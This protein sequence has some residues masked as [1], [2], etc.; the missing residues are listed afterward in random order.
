MYQ[1]NGNSS[2][3]I[4]KGK[5]VT[6]DT[7]FH[8]VPEKAYAR[9]TVGAAK[10]E[11]DGSYTGGV[12]KKYAKETVG[13]RKK[14]PD[15][16]YVGGVDPRFAQE[17]VETKKTSGSGKKPDPAPE[18]RAEPAR[19][20][21]TEP[22]YAAQRELDPDPK[23]PQ[24]TAAARKKWSKKQITVAA[25]I[26]LAVFLFVDPLIS[27]LVYESSKDDAPKEAAGQTFVQTETVSA[28]AG[29]NA[30]LAK[31][32]PSVPENLKEHMLLQMRGIG[33]CDKL[34]GDVGIT[35]IFA[36]DSESS[37]TQ[38]Q[39]NSYM[40]E[41]N[42]AVHALV[43]EANSRGLDLQIVVDQDHCSIEGV[44]TSSMASAYVGPILSTTGRDVVTP[45]ES[46]EKNLGVD[47]APVVFVFNK[48][49]RAHAW[50]GN[51]EYLFMFSDPSGF[52]H[53][54]LHL[55]GA[56]D[57]YYNDE[58]AALAEVYFGENV[59]LTSGNY[60]V[61]DLTAYLIGWTDSLSQSALKF[62]S[63]TAM[64][65]ESDLKKSQEENTFSGEGTKV[66]DDG[67]VYTGYM[68]NGM[69]MGW[70]EMRWASGDVYVGHFNDGAI[71]G[72]GTLTW[73]NGDVYE[74]EFL[75]GAL[76]GE[77]T[78]T[79]ADGTV[80]SGTWRNGEFVG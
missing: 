26:L 36:D 60:T 33:P 2:Y 19:E 8:V 42:V 15:G 32:L 48:N 38:T 47:E 22:V 57:Y 59:M 14:E 80:R 66:Y 50:Q 54:L 73:S 11:T 70:G 16:S 23:P 69:P 68:T 45:N 53:E 27:M 58:M 12:D 34:R 6:E 21:R 5:R 49:G 24:K 44:A 52:R 65:D 37:W 56:A 25:I 62:L 4:V 20:N 29:E 67:T 30:D 3:R 35:V 18:K 41:I 61:D 7:T 9:E 55:F 64:I 74:G 28:A 46:L 51:R 40:N 75:N 63:A 78:L 39:I 10:K 76:H 31:R 17:T 79:W 77:G 72:T 71:T 1:E 13:T 43:H